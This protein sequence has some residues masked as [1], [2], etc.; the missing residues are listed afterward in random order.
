MYDSCEYNFFIN[1]YN[2]NKKGKKEQ[3]FNLLN[4]ILFVKYRDRTISYKNPKK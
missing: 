2:K 3:N 4:K 1:N